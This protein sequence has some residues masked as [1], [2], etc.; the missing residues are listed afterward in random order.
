[1]LMRNTIKLNRTLV[2]IITVIITITIIDGSK[3]NVGAKVQG[4]VNEP[5]KV[6]VLLSSFKD[7]FISQVRENLE[8]IQ[9]ES[10]LKVEFTFFDGEGNQDIQ[11]ATLDS[12]IDDGFKLVLV[13]LVDI[14]GNEDFVKK[15]KFSNVPIIFFNVAPFITDHIKTY[16]KAFVIAT[17]VQESGVLEGNIIID[18]W[19][20]DKSLLDNNG[21][22][23]LQYVLLRAA[24]NDP[25][26]IARTKY[27]ILTI[28]NAGIKTE[29][30]ALLV[31]NSVSEERKSIGNSLEP[32]LLRY[33]TAIEAIIANTDDLA[34]GAIDVLR[35]YGYNDGSNTRKISVVGINGVPETID[36]VNKNIMDGTV[37]QD[38]PGMAMALYQVG[39]NLV[40]NKNPLDSTNYKVDESGVTV[41]LP[42]KG[43][44]KN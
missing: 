15:A 36:L 22:N 13:N 27:P 14:N 40:S 9:Q 17:D 38:A 2:F 30:I 31:A 20:T 33:G 18:K 26:N 44:V 1:M 11:K 8:K 16:S 25:L 12:V 37:L 35:K 34:L 23:V 24:V 42:Y 10:E 6:A 41:R 43:Y 19:K 5:I 32:I 39:M 29:E 4:V 28:N 21:D 3:T 7:L